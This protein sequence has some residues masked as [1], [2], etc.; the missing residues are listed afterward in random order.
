MGDTFILDS[1]AL[2]A[3]VKYKSKTHYPSRRPGRSN[4]TVPGDVSGSAGYNGYFTLKDVSTYTADGTVKEYRVAVCDGETWDP[5]TETSGD[6]I[7]YCNGAEIHFPC[8]VFSIKEAVDI[9]IKCGA[10]N[11]YLNKIVV[12]KAGTSKQSRIGYEYI[13]LAAVTIDSSKQL[14][15]KRLPMTESIAGLLYIPYNQYAGNF[16]IRPLEDPKTDSVIE[17]KA[18]VC[19][20]KTWDAVNQTSDFSTCTVNSIEISNGALPKIIEFSYE[21]KVF[22]RC[23]AGRGLPVEIISTTETPDMTKDG[24]YGYVLIAY[25]SKQCP[26]F[27]GMYNILLFNVGCDGKYSIIEDG[28]K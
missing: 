3:A 12:Q 10:G 24:V 8:T 16:S 11:K 20:G 4:L 5:E 15:I 25:H 18:V 23:D 19:D 14:N 22:V 28:E 6:S 1:P 21:R 7:A 2:E 26:P 9:Y 13:R 17:G 27:G